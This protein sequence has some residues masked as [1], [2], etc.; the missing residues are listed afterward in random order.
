MNQG[1]IDHP[2]QEGSYYVGVG[3]VR[4]LVALLGK[5]SDVP[6][7]GLAGL[8]TAVLE[9]PWVPR[10]FVRA[11]EVPHKDPLQIHP[12]LDRVGRQ[13]FQPCPGRI[14]QEQWKVADN[15]VIIVCTTG[16]IGKSIVF[17]KKSRV[18]PLEY[19]GILVGGRYLGGKAALRMCWPKA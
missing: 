3:N 10:A 12:T 6:A 15:E 18:C 1:L 4:E 2:R 16:L 17:K 7:E 11:L 8:L 13:V 9:V 19:L 5:A 14:G